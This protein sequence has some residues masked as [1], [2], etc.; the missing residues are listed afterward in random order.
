MVD[1]PTDDQQLE[2]LDDELEGLLVLEPRSEFDPAILGVVR[3]FNHTFTVYSERKVLDIIE[4]QM[5]PS[6]P[7]EDRGELAR[8]YFEF[9]VVGAWVGD[10]TPGFMTPLAGQEPILQVR[11]KGKPI[12]QGSKQV[13]Y[14]KASGQVR[15]REDAGVEHASWRR[16]ITAGVIESLVDPD[17]FPL[18]GPVGVRLVFYLTRGVGMYG[19]GR[20]GQ[21]LKASSP[22]H[23][24][25]P[26][27]VDKL[28]RAV[29]DACTD[30]R[31]WV[32]DA[33][34]VALSVRKEFIDRFGPNP[35]GV[36][37]TVGAL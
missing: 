6:E 34:V 10:D 33:Q 31:L 7:D 26:P 24:I 5:E 18:R 20:N 4:A 1:A 28:A 3:R 13:W 32:D 9:N 15:M 21:T 23:P 11:I 2:E 25:K 30:A 37:I 27:D 14:D 8:E 36:L 22:A 12:P 17:T 16:E 35:P 29:L 19:T